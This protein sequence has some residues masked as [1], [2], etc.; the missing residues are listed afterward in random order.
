MKKPFFVPDEIT[1][2]DGVLTMG[3][4]TFARAQLMREVCPDAETLIFATFRTW[5]LISKF[6]KPFDSSIGVIT[7][8]SSGKANCAMCSQK[9]GQS[10]KV[11]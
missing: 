11:Y 8:F 4:T 1:L 5:G 3:L 9:S 6:E 7:G 2:V 10:A